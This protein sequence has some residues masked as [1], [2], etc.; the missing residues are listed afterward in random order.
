MK[1]LNRTF[2]WLLIL[3]GGAHALGQNISGSVLDHEDNPLPGVN[4]LVKGTVK[5]AITDIDGNYSIDAN[6]GDVL[7]FS[8]IG[9]ENQ[10]V[11]VASDN[12]INIKEIFTSISFMRV[13]PVSSY[14]SCHEQDENLTQNFCIDSC[15]LYFG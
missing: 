11:V 1:S 5:G 7:S 10:E 14:Y 15:G 8:F 4:V 6:E 12:T 9:Y 3:L 2:L 13:L